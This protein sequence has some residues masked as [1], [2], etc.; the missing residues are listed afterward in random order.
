MQ[1]VLNTNDAFKCE[2]RFNIQF[3]TIK[4]KKYMKVKE[5]YGIKKTRLDNNQIQAMTLVCFFLFHNTKKM[6]II[7]KKIK[8]SGIR[9]K[10]LCG[11]VEGK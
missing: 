6:K 3:N 1:Q 9:W 10:E 7:I 2:K 5:K 11:N 4:I 8:E